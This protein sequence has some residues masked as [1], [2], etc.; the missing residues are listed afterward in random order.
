MRLAVIFFALCAAC[1]AFAQQLYRWVDQDGRVHI[2]DTPPPPGAKDVQ[3]KGGRTNSAV[4]DSAAEPYAV[5]VARQNSPVTLYTT[6]GCEACAEARKFLNARGVPFTEVS[7]NDEK[8]LTELK[9]AVGSNSVPS[10]IVGATVQKGFEA[11]AY[12]RILD[13]AGYPKA[14]IVPP[15]AQV[16][17]KSGDAE[18]PAKPAEGAPRGPYAPGAPRQ[19]VYKK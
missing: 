17:P 5:Q 19:P 15:R 4:P 1:A 14:G 10:I 7:V 3:R 18:E 11:G 16:E 8:A 13:A 6:P 2:T 9:N 12:N